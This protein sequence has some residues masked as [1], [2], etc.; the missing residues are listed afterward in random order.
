VEAMPTGG[1]V[2]ISTENQY[3]SK[4]IK[5]YD[6]IREGE[7]VVLK[8]TDDG[9][10]ISAEDIERIFEPF[11]SKKVMGRSGTGLG[12][13]VVWGTVKDHNGYIDVQ[14]KEGI[15]TTFM[16]YFPVTSE[17][18]V[19]SPSALKME[20]FRGEG[21][22]ILI[23]DDVEEQRTIATSILTKLNYNV[24]SVPS[25]EEALEYLKENAADILLI[26]MIMDPGMDGL[27]TFKKILEIHPG[28]KAVIASGFAETERVKEAQRLGAGHYIR[29]PYKIDTLGLAI[30]DELS[31]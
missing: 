29:K 22:S 23:I 26:D 27:E 8:I 24:A 1:T 15:G 31:K 20:D 5:G 6:H 25:G 17:K 28:Q 3:L 19:K 4:P 11:Y 12:M 7:Y 2:S 10:G 13:A 21:Q 9:L 14:S 30:K 16:L 18:F